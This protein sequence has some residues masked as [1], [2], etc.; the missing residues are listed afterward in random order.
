MTG[1]Q[2]ERKC[3][4]GLNKRKTEGMQNVDK[5]NKAGTSEIPA[6][7]RDNNRRRPIRFGL[8]IITHLA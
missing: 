3:D 2:K 4:F 6:M 1:K 7:K 5:I 8:F